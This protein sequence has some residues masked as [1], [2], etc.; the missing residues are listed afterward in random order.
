M[1][2]IAES[3]HEAAPEGEEAAPQWEGV[4]SGDGSDLYG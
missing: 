3:A 1:V 4:V 2:V